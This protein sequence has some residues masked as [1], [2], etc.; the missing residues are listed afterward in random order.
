MLLLTLFALSPADTLLPFAI[1]QW[2]KEPE[3]RVEDAYKWLFHATQGGEHAVTDDDGPRQWMDN[4]WDTLTSPRPNEPEVTKL[5]PTGRII[6]VNLRPYRAKHGDKEMLL[7]IF[8]ASAQQFKP[9]RKDFIS[10]WKALG[11]SLKAKPINL[12]TFK[13]W[14]VLDAETKKLGYPAIEHSSAYVRRYQPAYRVILGKL[15]AAGHVEL[16][17][18]VPNS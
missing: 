5:D 1:Q 9:D 14:L 10:E 15:W 11:K 3:M 7:A 6:R 18:L 2:R 4:E 8:V 12:L 13:S 16:S 17:V